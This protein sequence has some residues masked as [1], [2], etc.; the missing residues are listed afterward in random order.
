MS[1][2]QQML[3]KIQSFIAVGISFILLTFMGACVAAAVLP[4]LELFPRC[5]FI[6]IFVFSNYGFLFGKPVWG[7]GL[8]QT[9]C[10]SELQL[11][12]NLEVKKHFLLP[13][14][15]TNPPDLGLSREWTVKFD[16]HGD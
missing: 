10:H 16:S 5:S 4:H 14:K 8:M 12:E 1:G 15:D 2:L 3:E 7:K 11:A 13:N 6:Q 9:L